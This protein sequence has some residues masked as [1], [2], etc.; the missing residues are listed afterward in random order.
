DYGHCEL[1]HEDAERRLAAARARAV[2]RV[3]GVRLPALTHRVPQPA[4]VGGAVLHQPLEGASCRPRDVAEERERKSRPGPKSRE[5]ERVDEHE[6]AEAVAV[7]DRE[8]CRQRAAAEMADEDRRRVA[9]TVDQLAE[10]A[11]EAV[12]VELTVGR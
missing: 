2:E 10:P 11:Q 6:R 12:G 8:P 5:T 3:R 4:E 9:A 1:P 7:V